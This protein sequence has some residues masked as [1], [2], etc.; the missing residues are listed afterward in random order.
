MI[1]CL[2]LL[3][4]AMNRKFEFSLVILPSVKIHDDSKN[5]K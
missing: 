1:F 5:F 4:D 2:A 3:C